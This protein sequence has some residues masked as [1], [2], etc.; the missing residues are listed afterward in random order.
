[1]GTCSGPQLQST[2]PPAGGARRPLTVLFLSFPQPFPLFVCSTYGV[3]HLPQKTDHSS[4]G[5]LWPAFPAQT[6][7]SHWTPVTWKIE[8]TCQLRKVGEGWQVYMIFIN[9]MLR[10]TL[11]VSD[12]LK[13]WLSI[14]KWFKCRIIEVYS[15]LFV[16]A[17]LKR[18]YTGYALQ[19]RM[20]SRKYSG[21][22]VSV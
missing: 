12:I 19:Y 18:D 6:H 11:S 21:K 10:K 14:L 1:M 20:Q 3:Q 7:T 8:R 16:H 13:V 5:F 17:F 2:V 4:P 9:Q 22:Q 15:N